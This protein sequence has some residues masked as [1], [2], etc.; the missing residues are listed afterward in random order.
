[1][2]VPILKHKRTLLP[3]V[4]LARRPLR[5]YQKVML[6]YCLSVQHPALFVQMRLGKTLVT[7]RSIQVRH[8][9]KILVVAPY[10]AL[11]SWSIELELEQEQNVIELY[12][13]RNERLQVLDDQYQ[14]NK[15]FLFNKEGHRILPEIADFSFDIVVLDESTFVKAPYSS[16]KGSQ[17][18]RFYCQ[19][20]RDAMH[21]YI[22]TGTP[23]PESE[24]DYF[25][26][27][28]FLDW[29]LWREQN[30]WEFR[31][32]H[33]GIINHTAYI[34]P[35][36]SRYIENILTKNCFYLS[37]SDVKLG[38]KKIYE[39]RF[40]QLTD[41]VRK[42]YE[43]V[44]KEFVLEYLG[45]AQE[46]IYA[47]TKYVWLR[48]LCGGFV[49]NEFIS[50]VKLKEIENILTTELKGEQVVIVAKHVNEVLKISKYFTEKKFRVG[51][52][53]GAVD[54]R[55]KRPE[56]IKA[57]QTGKLD[58]VVVQPETVK[59]GTNL[60]ASDTIII[61]TTPDGGETRMQ[62][63][64]RIVNTA[65]N[66]SS[67]IIDIVCKDT[68]EEEVLTN[69]HKKESKQDLMKRTIQRLQKKYN[70]FQG[71]V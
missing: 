30:Y 17:V 69:L 24:L 27:L 42:I 5:L 67:L 63:E 62:I 65:T 2:I 64:D 51:T 57:F 59:H 18:T 44:E 14:Q 60:S 53:Y 9:S 47:T 13:S 50:Y 33:F 4:K 40:V 10:S 49:D 15:W 66:D 68:V 12:G 16:K 22:L 38:G 37:R 45:M 19:N 31:H 58:L 1:M 71:V 39:K 23:A 25:N 3:G 29:R 55:K 54:K 32:K 11:Y 21:R 26:Q 20:F 7:I 61:Y 70:L 6:Y 52:I 36:G 34:K 41:K 56:I 46:T 8:G 28:R 43:K 48:R 35:E